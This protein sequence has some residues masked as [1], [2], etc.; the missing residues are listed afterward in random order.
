MDAGTL[1]KEID[2][3]L[4]G[5]TP[6][7]AIINKARVNYKKGIADFMVMAQ[8]VNRAMERKGTKKKAEKSE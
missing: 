4:D 7:V 1:E 8:I 3:M 6:N 5:Q 2:K